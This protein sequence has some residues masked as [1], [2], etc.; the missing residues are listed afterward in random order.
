VVRIEPVTIKDDG[1][2]AAL[3]GTIG[4]AT[5]SVAGENKWTRLAGTIGGMVVGKVIG[6]AANSS[7]GERITLEMDDGR[8][9]A[10][11]LEI[12]KNYH[13]EYQ[14]GDRVAVF[15]LNGGVHRIERVKH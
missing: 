1:K 14:A 2:G 9:V 15:F 3:G 13:R 6:A 4:A 10:T 7:Q 8:I 11:E 12:D 5:G